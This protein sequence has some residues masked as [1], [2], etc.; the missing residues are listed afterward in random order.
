MLLRTGAGATHGRRVSLSTPSSAPP[1]GGSPPHESRLRRRKFSQ[2]VAAKT[3]TQFSS[4][5]KGSR[6]G[7]GKKNRAEETGSGD[8][9][10]GVP[11]TATRT[12]PEHSSNSGGDGVADL[13]RSMA[14]LK[15]VPPSVTR[16]K[17][18]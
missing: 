11:R 18:G 13:E 17:I 16:G 6:V 7:E 1:G 14:A 10:P 12:S 15:F 2:S 8:V 3:D 9:S 4:P 5:V